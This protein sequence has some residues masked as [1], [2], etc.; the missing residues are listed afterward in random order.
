MLSNGPGD[1][2]ENVEIIANIREMLS[3][4]IPTFG[5]C[6]GHQLTALA[7]GAN[8]VQAEVRPPRRQPAGHRLQPEPHLHHQ[9]EPRLR[10]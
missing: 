4:G 7:A 9:P 2:A 1:P 5:I 6:L 3:T 10:R 8:T